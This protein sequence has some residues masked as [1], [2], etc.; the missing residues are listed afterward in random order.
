ME[1]QAKWDEAIKFHGHSCPGLALGVR[2]SIIALE[3]L[4]VS[5]A[6]DEEL[7]AIVETDACG[8]D[9]VQFIV[10]CTL[11]KGNLVFKDYGKQVYTI[12]RRRDGKGVRVAFNNLSSNEE[13]KKL[14]T[15][16]FGG[17]ATQ[18]EKQQF[19][20]LQEKRIK[21]ILFQPEEEVCKV[22]MMDVK[23]PGKARIFSSILCEECGEY[24]MEP[25]GRMQYGKIVCLSCFQD[26]SRQ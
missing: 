16:V 11:G 20:E 14:G 5:R 1:L 8:V 2:A 4:G 26:Y 12:A 19:K 15:K 10:G 24:F 9:G 25:R 3:K 22:Q 7:I 6:E 21:D 18:E 17:T 23:L 13:Q